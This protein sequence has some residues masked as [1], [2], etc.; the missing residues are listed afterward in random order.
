MTAAMGVSASTSVERD[1]R[2]LRAEGISK[3]F[4]G[5]DALT[6][7]DLSLSRAEV[8]GLIGPNGSG[9]TTL[10]NIL[11][12][13]LRATSG[14]ISLGG[15]DASTWAPYRIARAGVS[16]TFQNVR[17]FPRLTVLE[18][19][20]V[21]AAG[22]RQPERGA[23]ARARARAAL[24]DFEVAHLAD[25]AADELPYGTRRRVDMARALAAQPE[26]L[27][28]DEPAAGLSDAETTSLRDT[29]AEIESKRDIG[30]LV[31]DHDLRLIQT[32][33]HRIVVLDAG[34]VISR[35]T[36]AEV[37]KDRAVIDAYLGS[38]G[39]QQLVDPRFGRDNEGDIG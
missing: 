2:A 26:F 7:V 20:E 36:P 18:N 32:L 12:G 3:A 33:C 38:H 34:K 16:R 24:A 37:M 27:L 4:A 6:S 31:I 8:V 30:I 21:G 29:V 22:G 9:K 14:R 11:S 39:E 13:L 5:V 28:L 1:P 15:S 19:V 17:L 23:R 10:I 25:R 35:G